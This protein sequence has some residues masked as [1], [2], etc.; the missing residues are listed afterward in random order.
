MTLFCKQIIILLQW[1]LKKNIIRYKKEEPM[2]KLLLVA[3][4]AAI[5]TIASAAVSVDQASAP[6]VLQN[7]GYSEEMT[8][9]V[10]MSKARAMGQ[11]YYTKDEAAFKKQNK[12]VRF[13]RKLYVY[14]DPAAEDYSFYHH[15][16]DAA[17]K[18]SD[19]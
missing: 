3:I 11:E 2:K 14:T 6:A 16:I 12:F 5:P 10:N 17:P 1:L 19:L 4:A 18:Y 9:M 8:N 13:W 7:N 15:N